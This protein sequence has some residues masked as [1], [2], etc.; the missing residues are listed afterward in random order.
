MN[1][2]LKIISLVICISFILG[3]LT[4]GSFAESKE[5]EV[6]ETIQLGSYPQSKVTDME[7]ID[8]L[9][10]ADGKWLSYRYYEGTGDL[11]D[12]QMKPSD[13]MMYRDVTLGD[14]KYRGVIFTEYRPDMPGDKCDASSS[15][16]DDNGYYTNVVYWFKYE[17]LVWR[18]LDPD[19][20]LIM[21]ESVIDAQPFNNYIMQVENFYTN[22]PAKEHFYNNYAYSSVRTWLNNDFYNTA[23]SE[24]EKNRIDISILNNSAYEKYSLYDSDTTKDNIFLLSYLEAL[25]DEYGFLRDD[26]DCEARTAHGTDYARSQ[27]FSANQSEGSPKWLLRTAGFTSMFICSVD[28]VY[29]GF[30]YGRIPGNTGIRPACRLRLPS[31]APGDVD[32]DGSVLANDARLALRASALL[33]DLNEKQKKVADVDGNGE[34]FADDARKILRVS[35]EIDTFES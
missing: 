14:A 35:A 9:N 5:Y 15:F 6:G 27:G 24:T 22:S 16:Q 34:V 3:V 10:S 11:Y 13:Y 17:P 2:F 28:S 33:E 23:F 29:G 31:Y 21:C 1:N 4:F 8:A 32:G 26:A 18:I 19:E 7:L 12:G 30:S 25:N 20:G